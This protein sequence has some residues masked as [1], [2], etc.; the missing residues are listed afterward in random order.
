MHY[1]LRIMNYSKDELL[2]R[3]REGGKLNTSEQLRLTVLLSVPAILAQA[4][5]I[6]MFYIDD[7]MVGSLGALASA[8][9][10]LV[11]TTMWLYWSIIS[12]VSMGFSVQV[13]HLIGA[14]RMEDARNVFRQGIVTAAIVCLTVM[15]VCA[16]IAFPLP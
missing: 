6:L 16:L 2:S 10:G 11:A 4:A 13:A 5:S 7:A 14:N 15:A 8:S 12:C 1:A 9:I 3:I